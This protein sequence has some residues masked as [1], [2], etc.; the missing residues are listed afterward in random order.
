[1]HEPS[2]DGERE[3]GARGEWGEEE[4]DEEE[5]EKQRGGQPILWTRGETRGGLVAVVENEVEGWVRNGSVSQSATVPFMWLVRMRDPSGER[6]ICTNSSGT[7]SFGVRALI[8]VGDTTCP[9]GFRGSEAQ[10]GL[11]A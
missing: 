9:I 1:M 6:L 5:G 3:G 8:G 2:H 10:Q 4:E 7:A 11:G